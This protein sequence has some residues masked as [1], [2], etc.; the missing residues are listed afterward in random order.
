MNNVCQNNNFNLFHSTVLN[1]VAKKKS[2]T[3]TDKTKT[4]Q[5]ND[6]QILTKKN[7]L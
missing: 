6:Q 2:T 3:N 5:K 4:K 7:K 1:V